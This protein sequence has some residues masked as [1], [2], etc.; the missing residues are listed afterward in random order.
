VREVTACFDALSYRRLTPEQRRQALARL[1]LAVNRFL[2]QQSR[3]GRRA[4]Q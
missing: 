2:R 1:K 3:P 4:K